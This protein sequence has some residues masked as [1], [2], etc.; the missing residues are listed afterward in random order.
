M[1]TKEN[2]YSLESARLG[3]KKYFAC[4]NLMRYIVQN[5]LWRFHF[6]RWKNHHFNSRRDYIPK[7]Y[8]MVFCYLK[9]PYPI[10]YSVLV[11]YNFI[12]FVIHEMF[13]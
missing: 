6:S 9:G 1:V 7:L 11:M 10:C 2:N 13:F 8:T 5:A 12:I 4:F 3:N